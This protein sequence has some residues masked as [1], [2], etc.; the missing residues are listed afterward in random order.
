M[1]MTRGTR[2][3]TTL[4][5]PPIKVSVEVCGMYK[6]IIRGGVSVLHLLFCLASL[7]FLQIDRRADRQTGGQTGVPVDLS[8]L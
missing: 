8:Q 4:K 1:K 5:P 6:S 7:G 2:W 3:L